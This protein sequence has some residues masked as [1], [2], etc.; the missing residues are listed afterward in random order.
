M[1]LTEEI[2]K[3][4]SLPYNFVR[5]I[6][7]LDADGLSSAGIVAT[8]LKRKGI[9][10]HLSI[11]KQLDAD[12]MERI[13]N[14]PYDQYILLDFGSAKI[15]EIEATGKRFVVLDHH[16]PIK[17]SENQVNPHFFG[18]DGSTKVSA[19]GLAYMFAKAMD[20]ANSDLSHLAIVGAIGDQQENGEFT[21]LNADL[22]KEATE[23]GTI[24]VNKGLRAFGRVSRPVHRA[25]Q[26]S[27]DP[28]I[29]GVSGS[30]SGAIEFLS[31][32]GI[33]P[34]DNGEWRTISDLSEDE[35]K[36]LV[37]AVIIRRSGLSKP[38]DVIGN[39]YEVQGEEGLLSD[40]QEFS[41]VLN[42]LGRSNRQSVA[43]GLIIGDKPKALAQ[44]EEILFEYKKSVVQA[45][46]VVKSENLGKE[47]EDILYIM[48]GELIDDTIIGTVT[49]IFAMSADLS[50]KEVVVGFAKRKDGFKISCRSKGMKVGEL[51]SEIATQL[52]GEGGGHDVAAGAQIP[53]DS[54]EQFTELFT[55]GV[56]RLKNTRLTENTDGKTKNEEVDRD[57]GS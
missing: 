41:T 22:L 18:I 28:F 11:I 14:E 44:M 36:K 53:K 54:L 9:G 24:R 38:S 30:E 8:A 12:E 42:A 33:L 25:L 5:V 21:G 23:V 20:P 19:S 3:V 2:E 49:S 27:T 46:N 57:N 7:H 55:A 1:G 43:M 52:G 26:Y 16:Q 10:F 56:K 48:G 35:L 39:I 40:V 31:Q 50:Q 51:I 47:E 6:S 15:E 37:S 34:Q 45:I 17:E 32:V 4:A 13:A 29:P